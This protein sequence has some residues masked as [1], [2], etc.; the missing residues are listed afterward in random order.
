MVPVPQHQPITKEGYSGKKIL[1]PKFLICGP[2]GI[3]KNV[4]FLPDV[5]LKMV[6]L[7][8][9]DFKGNYTTKIMFIPTRIGWQRLLLY[10]A[11]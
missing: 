7:K 1:W 10:M 8:K 4:F 9:K 3:K 2:Q 6:L 5:T 11:R